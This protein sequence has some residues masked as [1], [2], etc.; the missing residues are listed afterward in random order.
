MDQL[1]IPAKLIR[2]IKVCTYNSKSKVSF[3]RELSHKFPVTTSLR[4]SDALLPALFNIALELIMRIL[5]TKA[6]SIKI[7]KQSRVNCSTLCI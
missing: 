4:Q 2:M 3:G 1:G 5:M 6:K 7:K